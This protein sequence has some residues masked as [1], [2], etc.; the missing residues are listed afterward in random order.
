MSDEPT[1]QAA[2]RYWLTAL[3]EQVLRQ[4]EFHIPEHEA[5]EHP[6]QRFTLDDLGHELAELIDMGL[7]AVTG[8]YPNLRYCL[9]PEGCEVLRDEQPERCHM[10]RV[11]PLFTS[12]D[13]S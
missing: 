10:G 12:D 1:P 9:T 8:T 5:P 3:G 2:A 13:A 11:I 4:N 6:D 7:V